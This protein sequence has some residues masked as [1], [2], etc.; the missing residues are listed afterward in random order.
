MQEFLVS[1][2]ISPVGQAELPSPVNVSFKQINFNAT[3]FDN[4]TTLIHWNPGTR[5]VQ[6][7]SFCE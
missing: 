2:T 7:Y 3:G 1:F 6:M 5:A 4:I